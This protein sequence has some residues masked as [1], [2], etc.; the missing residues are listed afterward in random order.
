MKIFNRNKLFPLPLLALCLLLAAGCGGEGDANAGAAAS[1]SAAAASAKPAPD[2]ALQTLDG[3]TVRLSDLR[4][5]VVLVDFWATWCP[6]CRK[7][8]P[9]LQE[10]HE[11][12]G[13]SGLKVVGIATDQQG[14][15]VVAPFVEENGLTFTVVL[16]DGKVDRDFGGIRGIPTTFV[17]DPQ[18]RIVGKFVGYQDK[19]IYR[20]AVMS[21]L[22]DRS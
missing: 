17:I 1:G 15:K 6:P 9:H 13:D 11:E 22:P 20:D 10:L 3:G 16:T 2:F 14:A 8:L 7:A 18:G 21:V 5:D 4:G 12:L 19:Q